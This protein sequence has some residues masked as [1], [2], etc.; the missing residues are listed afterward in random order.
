MTKLH[1]PEILS[2]N[3]IYV[4]NKII[5]TSFP[6]MKLKNKIKK[7]TKMTQQT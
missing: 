1:L 7:K 5:I 4:K 3:K 6:N 2:I